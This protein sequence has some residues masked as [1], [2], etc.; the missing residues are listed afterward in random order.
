V[1]IHPKTRFTLGVGIERA[2]AEF[3]KA[4]FIFHNDSDNCFKQ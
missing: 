1:V 4:V 3:P 2:G